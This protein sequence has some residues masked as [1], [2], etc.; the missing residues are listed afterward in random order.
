MGF[1]KLINKFVTL[2][3]SKHNLLEDFFIPIFQEAIAY[4]RG[5]GYFTSGWLKSMSKGIIPL[6]ERG[7]KIRLITSPILQPMDYEA[8]RTG[9]EGKRDEVVYDAL[10]RNVDQLANDLEADARSALSWMIADEMLDLKFAV[11]N[12]K[13]EGGD[14]HVKFGIFRDEKGREIAFTGSYNDTSHANLNFEEIAAF[15]SSDSSSLEII[16][17]K[18]RL[19]E[20]L[21]CNADP[22]LSVYAIPEA[23]KQ[24]FVQIARKCERPYKRPSQIKAI[25][26]RPQA[27]LGIHPWPVQ[28]RGI[29]AWRNAQR[30]GILEMATGT[31]KTKTALFAA[32]ELCNEINSLVIIIACPQKP[33]AKQWADECVTFNMRP[34]L[35]FSDNPKWND[36]VADGIAKINLGVQKYLTIVATHEALKSKKLQNNL[37]RVN[38]KQTKIMLIAD[39]CHHLGTINSKENT[40][41][42]ADYALGLSATPQ[43]FY[44]EDGTKFIESL[45]GP[46]IFKYSLKEAIGD[47]IL[48]E[49]EYHAHPVYLDDEEAEEYN[50]LSKSIGQYFAACKFGDI[51]KLIKEDRSLQALLHRRA[52]II[53][54]AKAKVETLQNILT[55][56]SQRIMHTV[57][58]CAPDTD[59][60]EKVALMLTKNGIVSRRFTGEES[61]DERERIIS[62]FD[63]GVYQAITAMNIFN[64][65]IDIPKAKNAFFLSSS[66][67]PMEYVQ[68]RGRVLRKTSDGSKA[69]AILHDFIVL[70]PIGEFGETSKYEKRMIRKELDRFYIFAE[71]SINS[72]S[73]MEKLHSIVI[74]YFDQPSLG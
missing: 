1:E 37:A 6:V 49:Y 26:F 8:I 44:D 23:L 56:A 31:G 5:V 18:K 9:D 39:E 13:L 32:A 66:K 53:K 20:R 64:E 19:F 7:G 74:K 62:D 73:E 12:K 42:G 57:I 65:G 4:D 38:K 60:L 2:D 34:V 46:N 58:F 28:E 48:C 71:D 24:K 72:L 52:K 11:P 54:S 41:R 70:P 51:S 61:S 59:E 3:S 43:R 33:L 45:I 10:M 30:R 27:P 67:N 21:W 36:E 17:Q 35:A 68:R 22:N 50:S 16:D 63:T 14:F 47:K 15:Y 25:N 29:A 40:F 55:K 69:K